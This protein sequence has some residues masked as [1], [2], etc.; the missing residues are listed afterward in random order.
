MDS[1]IADAQRKASAV[2]GWMAKTAKTMAAARL[3][4]SHR[5]AISHSYRQTPR[6]VRSTA[7]WNQKG[8]G[9]V[10]WWIDHSAMKKRGR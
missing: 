8:S 9:P 1:E 2:T 10:R 5:R 6:W 4:S 3:E 7:R